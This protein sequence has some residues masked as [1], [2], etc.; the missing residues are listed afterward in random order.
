MH[1]LLCAAGLCLVG[2][3]EALH[4]RNTTIFNQEE[5]PDQDF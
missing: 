1:A 3:P 5:Y 4:E 2:K